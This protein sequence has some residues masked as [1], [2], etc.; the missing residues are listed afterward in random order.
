MPWMESGQSWNVSL[1]P[2]LLSNLHAADPSLSTPK[3]LASF[4]AD[5]TSGALK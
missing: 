2:E 1:S 3:E 4:D 5:L